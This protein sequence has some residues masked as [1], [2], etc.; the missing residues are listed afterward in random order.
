MSKNVK[1]LVSACFGSFTPFH[2]LHTMYGVLQL[3]PFGVPVSVPFYGHDVATS[4]Y[5]EA[6]KIK[7][8]DVHPVHPWIATAD[9]DNN[10][11]VW[12]YATESIVLSFVPESIKEAQRAAAE[13]MEL[14]AAFGAAQGVTVPDVA[15]PGLGIGGGN[16][17]GASAGSATEAFISAATSSARRRGVLASLPEEARNAR[18]GHVRGVRFADE[19]GAGVSRASVFEFVI[20]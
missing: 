16:N 20:T 12:D 5:A 11:V 8:L 14:H 6:A 2:H 13:E 9:E 3:S 18:C 10:V 15:G 1:S 7:T 17:P 4:T 19:H